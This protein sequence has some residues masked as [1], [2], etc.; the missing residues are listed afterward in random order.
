MLQKFKHH[1][2]TNFPLLKDAKLL[3]TVSGGIDSVI[4]TH[5]LHQLNYDISIAHCNFCLRGKEANNDQ[6]F[7]K[8]IALKLHVPFF[9]TSFNTQ[10][11]AT[12]HKLS[13]QEAAR[14]LRYKWFY[15]LIKEQQLDF[16]I[17]AHNLNDSLET[18]L[19]NLSRG[20]GLKGLVGIPSINKKTIRPLLPFSRKEITEFALK[21]AVSWQEDSSN[22]N[23]KYS[24]NKIRH[25][26]IPVLEEINPNVLQSFQQTLENLQG[27][28]SIIANSVTKVLETSTKKNTISLKFE[29]KKIKKL[30]NLKTYI[31]EIFSEY[32]FTNFEDI[33]SLLTAQ[34][35][36]Q[37]FSK[38][39][40]LIKDREYLL[41]SKLSTNNEEK[42]TII[43]IFENDTEFK[44]ANVTF[45][46]QVEKQY[47]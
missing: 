4:L 33:K 3:I 11:F 15:E 43:T 45:K 29:I 41:L 42:E 16:I 34:S 38:T 36:K 14:N 10:N 30:K 40:R 22:V 7:V 6:Q 12:A 24:R 35:G 8:N 28:A 5:L 19:I 21:N 27:S 44:I 31:Y 32:N 13:I 46:I 25:Q 18:F 47:V 17:T 20:T 23:T 26:I 9:T 37:L 2:T 39:H 1:I